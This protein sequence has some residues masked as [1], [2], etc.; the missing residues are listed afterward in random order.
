MQLFLFLAQPE[1]NALDVIQL[2]KRKAGKR[3][4]NFKHE[5]LTEVRI[6]HVIEF[7]MSRVH[8]TG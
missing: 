4:A 2:V 6:A 7:G 1:I 8:G 5:F 3:T